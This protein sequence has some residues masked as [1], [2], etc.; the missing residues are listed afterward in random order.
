VPATTLTSRPIKA[1]RGRTALATFGMALTLLAGH[2][3]VV[4]IE[5]HKAEDH[6]SFG[7][8][9]DTCIRASCLRSDGPLDGDSSAHLSDSPFE[10]AASIYPPMPQFQR[11]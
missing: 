1:L 2:S 10:S 11:L 5:K 6:M 8:T 9:L 3:L 7:A 4:Q